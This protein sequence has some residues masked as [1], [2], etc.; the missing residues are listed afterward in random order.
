MSKKDFCSADNISV[1]IPYKQLENM[2]NVASS[3]DEMKRTVSL[4]QKQYD[5]MKCMYI[6]AL[7]KIQEIRRMV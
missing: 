7:D 6:E 4:M 1:I 3:L 2:L 5:A